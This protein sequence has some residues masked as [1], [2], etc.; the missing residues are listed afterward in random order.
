M[1]YILYWACLSLLVLGG[2]KSCK[3]EVPPDP[4]AGYKPLTANFKIWE[5][6]PSQDDRFLEW[7]PKWLTEDTDSLRSWAFAAE[8]AEPY[9]SKDSVQYKWEIG[10]EIL[11][12]KKISRFF[13]YPYPKFIDIKLTV[14]RRSKKECSPLDSNDAVFTRRLYVARPSL[15]TGIWHGYIDNN[16]ND[17]LTIG[18]F[19]ASLPPPPRNCGYSIWNFPSRGFYVHMRGTSTQT[20]ITRGFSNICASP[21]NPIDRP[22]GHIYAHIDKKT[23]EISA[24]G[25]YGGSAQ[26]DSLLRTFK[27]KKIR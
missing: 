26:G 8:A 9:L 18:F 24:W 15:F 14:T 21:T 2:C 22:W 13:L 6:N 20:Q 3:D 10:S 7:Y 27:G 12:T 17:T 4:C 1:R 16:V 25:Y 19:G 11:R 23:G 5:V